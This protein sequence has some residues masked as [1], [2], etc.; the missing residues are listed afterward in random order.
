MMTEKRFY[1]NTFYY[2]NTDRVME[3]EIIDR[4]SFPN[5]PNHDEVEE[6]PNWYIYINENDSNW[7]DMCIDK[8]N[9]LHEENEQLKE[10]IKSLTSNL[11]EDY[12]LF[13]RDKN[14]KPT[15]YCNECCNYETEYEEVIAFGD[16]ETL[17]K[18]SCRE[19]HHILDNTDAT[20]C[21]DYDPKYD[22]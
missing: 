14:A 8:L 10:E 1:Y 21:P 16:Y 6:V 19:G 20:D 17:T 15:K 7:Q 2:P 12:I 4:E 18:I 9:E 3:Y 5:Y 22:E 11:E 13:K